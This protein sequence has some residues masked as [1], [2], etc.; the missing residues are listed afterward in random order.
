MKPHYVIAI[1]GNGN[2]ASGVRSVVFGGAANAVNNTARQLPAG[3]ATLLM[4]STL[5]A[6]GFNKAS[7]DSVQLLLVAFQTLPVRMPVTFEAEVPTVGTV[8][9]P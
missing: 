2:V 4:A 6:G 3:P 1:G 8:V 7:N 5:R 9:G